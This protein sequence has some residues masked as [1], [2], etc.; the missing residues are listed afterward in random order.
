VAAPSTT[1]L[2]LDAETKARVRRLA[3]ARR[4]T[5]HWIMREAI[6][7]YVAREELR[8]DF[9]REAL[10]SWEHFQTTGLHVTQDE[11]DAWFARVIAGE[12]DAELPLLHT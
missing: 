8:E 9:K 5:S 11:M 12:T 1:S 4:R 10:E 6:E 2:K 3:D 7:Q